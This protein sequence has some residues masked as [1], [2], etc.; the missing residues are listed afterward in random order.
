MNKKR[1]LASFFILALGSILLVFGW[2]TQS[3]Q[4][5]QQQEP[6]VQQEL[7]K[8]PDFVAYRHLFHHVAAFN[9]EAKRMKNEGKDEKPFKEFFKRKAGL[10]EDQAHAL[11]EVAEAYE[12]DERAVLLRAKDLIDTYKAQYP[13]G[14]VPHG[15]KPAPPPSELRALTEE[16]N[17]IVLRWR[18]RLQVAL[19]NN[20]FNRFDNFVRRRVAPKVQRIPDSKSPLT[21]QGEQ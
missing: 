9:K 2:Q 18:D 4:L 11:E 17:A 16:H 5:S 14:Q 6:E 3:A 19:G 21:P 15:T 13:G 1:V 7:P 10:T 8:V 20:E 12:Q